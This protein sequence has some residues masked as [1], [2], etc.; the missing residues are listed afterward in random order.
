VLELC[1]I[2]GVR[3]YG[4]HRPRIASAP[5]SAMYANQ[6]I[7][8]AFALKW[9]LFAAVL[10]AYF[11]AGS[12]ALAEDPTLSEM[13]HTSW[14]A[15]DGAPQGITA[16]SQAPDNVL[17]IGTEGGLFSFDGR[18]FNA[19]VSAPGEPD[20]PGGSISTVLA[21]RD[22]AVWIGFRYGAVVR[23]LRGR[24][25]VFTDADGLRIAGVK[26]IRQTSD[27]AVWALRQQTNLIRFGADE[28]WH[29]EP[30]PLGNLGGLIHNF[31]IDSSDTLWLAQGGRLF[32]RPLSQSR[33]FATEAKAD[34]PFGFAETRDHSFWVNDT[35][36]SVPGQ[37]V[38]RT[39]HIDRFGKL[40]GRLP[41]EQRV[42]AILYAHDGSLI[43]LPTAG[44]IARISAQQLTGESQ[45]GRTISYDIYQQEDGLSAGSRGV[46]LLDIDDNLWIGGQRGLDRF[47]SARLVP[48]RP[49]AGSANSAIG[50][51]VSANLCADRDG[52]I[53][54]N[55]DHLEL[56]KFSSEKTNLLHT[57]GQ[58]YSMSCGQTDDLLLVGNN[59]IFKARND[60]ITLVPPIPGS[61]PA[62]I[63]QV[64]ASA[65]HT[66]FAVSSFGTSEVKGVW[67]YS[68][69]VWT[70]LPGARD[71]AI[72]PT[73]EY[74][75]TR[76]RLW[77]GY[78]DG[79]ISRPIENG[80]ILS[81]GDPGLGAVFA[82]LETSH[83]LF[84]GGE[85]GLAVLRGDGFEMLHFADRSFSQ[86]IGGLVESA[87]GDLW[88]NAQRGVVS[89]QAA[90]LQAALKTP[91]YLMKT[92]S[93][94][95]GNFVGPIGLRPGK[96][97]TARD[98]KGRLWF[99]T[100]NGAF[101]IDPGHPI[102]KNRLPNLSIKS[103]T[104]DRQPIDDGGNIGP[105]SQTL[106]IH[107]LGVNLTTPERV[108]Y[109]Y[110]LDGVDTEW[111]DVG[112]RT[113]AIYTQLQPGRYT[114]N[115]IASNG[116]GIWT[117]PLSS[118]PLNVLPRFYQTAWFIV[119][120]V[121]AAL[122]LLWFAFT[123]RVRAVTSGIRARAEERAEERVRIAR[124]LHDTLL[125]GI[126]GLL[127]TVH[128]AAQKVSRGE[129]AKLLLDKAL[130]TADRITIEGRNRVTSLRSEHLTDAELVGSIE[131]TGRD[132]NCDDT[133]EFQVKREGIDA[134]LYAHVADEAFCIVREA[135][136]N[137]FRHAEA[138]N[139]TVEVRYGRRHFSLECTDNG[140]GF[141]TESQDKAGHWGLKGLFERAEQLGGQ[142]HVRS[143]LERGTQ[144]HFVLPS[145]RAYE[146]HSRLRFYL[147]I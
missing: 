75:D 99:L 125:Q 67:R 131:N 101:H 128:V 133:I 55:A 19:F 28:A 53:W 70:K 38:G 52:V 8:P 64:V 20:L 71:G 85:N 90:E 30:T 32:R 88:L 122:L 102:S 47:R 36:T 106:N 113:E 68:H 37:P 18:A 124:D 5:A 46:L 24:V 104:M 136:T 49:E 107:Y 132:L 59:G 43:M 110:R 127:L 83:G 121:V 84:A 17:W 61:Y 16:L 56:Y 91:H 39:Q 7:T 21:T 41:I 112:H 23:I 73:I 45:A 103:I 135:L 54:V 143:E 15:R 12:R 129:D 9:L 42:E 89:I 40:L 108:T 35:I 81:S 57:T 48:F 82:V 97:T 44:G 79:V 95:E 111:Q 78:R 1:D 118:I 34:F 33:Y 116:D 60:R 51:G 115:V 27:G 14:A 74:L 120:I 140:R 29:V 86:G 92:E 126:Q 123:L 77:V 50:L 22:G 144:V 87:N 10:C 66:L 4:A 130:S 31:F 3:S 76:G 147:H 96:S 26:A 137:A 13:N 94:T 114:F 105:G 145:Y 11:S 141:D 2:P 25:K 80:K 93:F 98:A 69:D 138:S 139:I 146:N 117:A 62:D 142:V 63:D 72:L 65:D 119:S 6:S 134:T 58:I 100:L 109:K